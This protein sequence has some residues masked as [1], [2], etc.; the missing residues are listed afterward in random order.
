[1]SKFVDEED[2]YYGPAVATALV[3]RMQQLLMPSISSLPAGAKRSNLL[4]AASFI[5]SMIL[6]F[7]LSLIFRSL[8]SL[9][10]SA[11][12]SLS[13]SSSFTNVAKI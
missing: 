11:L 1:M 9:L 4:Q 13:V 10:I 3:S 7:V 5:P 2:S 12:F 8:F 6:S